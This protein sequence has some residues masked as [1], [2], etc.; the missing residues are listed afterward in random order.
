MRMSDESHPDEA[1]PPALFRYSSDTNYLIVLIFDSALAP[2]KMRELPDLHTGQA[3]REQGF[4]Q[5]AAGQCIPFALL[6]SARKGPCLLVTAGVHG[7]GFCAIEV[8]LRLSLHGGDLNETL[9]TFSLFPKGNAPSKTLA[10]VL[11]LQSW[12]RPPARVTP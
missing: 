11:G 1:R 6:G 9:T 5:R 4:L 12:S 10:T 8:A 7:S 3:R 2:E